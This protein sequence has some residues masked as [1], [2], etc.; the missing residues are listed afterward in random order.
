M[1]F[2]FGKFQL[3]GQRIEIYLPESGIFLPEGLNWILVETIIPSAE[4]L[5]NVCLGEILNFWSEN[6]TILCEKF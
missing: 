6:D 2:I 1:Q 5:N 4:I 3:S